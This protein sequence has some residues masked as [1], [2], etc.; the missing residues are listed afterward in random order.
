LNAPNSPGRSTAILTP[1][2]A[3]EAARALVPALGERAASCE[4]L[5]R[6]PDE[7]IDDLYACG[8]MRMMQPARWGGSELGLE[9]LLE[10]TIEL[11]HGCAS[12]AWV[13]LNLATHSWNIGQFGLEAQQDVWGSDPNA[14]AITGLAFPSGRATPVAGGYR[15]S[16]RWPFGSGVDAAQWTIVGAP[17]DRGSGTTPERRFFLVPRAEFRSLDDWRAYGLTGSGSHSVEVTDAFVPEHRSLLAQAFAS[18]FDCP[19]AQSNAN[20]LYRTPP[21]AGFNFALA[22]VPLGIAKAAVAAYVASAK[23]RTGT[24]TG[25]RLSDFTSIQM[26]IA[27]TSACVDLVEASLRSD[28]R[29]FNAMIERGESPSTELRLR[30]KR[31]V[32]FGV[33]LDVRAVDALMVASGAGGLALEAPLQRHFRDVHAAAAHFA[34]TWD[35]QASAYGQSALG[36]P[37][38]PGLLL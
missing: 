24:Y 38:P 11:C 25:A 20:T 3:L 32:A 31:N 21:F 13:W 22:M 16:G 8:L 28:L 30:W 12:T 27:E 14:V 35:V 10:V 5:R 18:G 7:T 34:L 2:S 4:A 9:P 26:R 36:L 1:T 29:E 37:D 33:T 6:C 15:V 17:V 23:R 19:G